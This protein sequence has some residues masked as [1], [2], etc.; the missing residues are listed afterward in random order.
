MAK[1]KKIAVEDLEEKKKIFEKIADNLEIVPA[2]VFLKENFIPYSWSQVL[3][4]ALSDVSGLKPVQRRILY[5]MYKKGLKHTANRSKVATLAG[6]V[7]EYHPHGDASVMD[8]LKNLAR[9]HVFRVPLID[10]KGDFGEPGTPGAAGRYIEA[11][12]S[13]A[14][15][16]NVEEIDEHAVTMI[17]NYDNTTEEPAKL[18]VK[19]PVALI[20]GGS[21]IAVGYASNMPSH[22]PTEI[23]TL[24]KALL[25]NPDM[26]LDDVREIVKGP[27]FNMG[28]TIT[29]IDGVNEYLDTGA[30]SFKIRAN[31]EVTQR[32]RGSWRIEFNE[33]PFGTWPEKI[34]TQIQSQVE[35]N[36]RFTEIANYKDLSDRKHP[37]RVVID[38]KSN[39]NYKQ[40]LQDLFKYTDLEISFAANMT[41]IIDHKPVQTSMKELVQNFIDFRKLCVFNKTRYNLGRKESRLH[42]IEGLLKVL[43]DIDKAIEIIRGSEDSNEA[44]TKLQEAFNIDEKQA[45]YVLSLQLRRLTKM[46]SLE[47]DNEKKTI[48]EEINYMNSLLTDENVLKEYLT[49]EFDETLKVIRDE[50]KT[51]ITGLTEEE[52]AEQM[53]MMN[54]SLK[55]ASK[56]TICYVTRFQN[57][58]LLK[59]EEPFVYGDNERA[60]GNSPIIEQLKVKT[61]ENITLVFSDGSAHSIPLSYLG[62]NIPVTTDKIGL[63]KNSGVKLVALGKNS[64]L[65]TDVGMLLATVNGEVKIVKPELPTKDEF[66]VYNLLDGDSILTGFWLG[67]TLTDTYFASI[68]SDSQ[69]LLYDATSVRPTGINA[70]GVKSHKLRTDKD[71][72]VAFNIVSKS[73]L[74]STFTISQSQHSLKLTPTAQIPPKGRGSMGVAL[75][76]FKRTET[77]LKNAYTGTNIV[78]SYGNANKT[79]PLPKLTDRARVGDDFEM[80]IV[81]GL[82]EASIM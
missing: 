80:P 47:L 28:G 18:P 1:R 27:D 73:N 74:N 58:T 8:A 79:V 31:F 32:P 36:N 15:W 30:G 13:K 81:L 51:E 33:I 77:S 26:S 49:N 46:D 39:V 20:N 10:G 65:K 23:M 41:T 5:T 35:K 60:L 78:A 29:T 9:R 7:L 48:T 69:M 12:L 54:R 76:K 40:V 14:A 37:I 17:P 62:F 61:Q 2:D 55:E 82:R 57:G 45:D 64:P 25:E 72:I 16:L 4:R 50:R 11:R 19:W 22:N 38:T 67:K 3:S 52:F 24:C 63:T 68:S 75:H 44:K 70:G 43:V 6:G 66:T 71:K 56:N 34:I 53:K 21:G 42:L 59:S